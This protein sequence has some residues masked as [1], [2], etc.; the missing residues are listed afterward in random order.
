MGAVLENI[1]GLYRAK[2]VSKSVSDA[3]VSI[4]E[5]QLRPGWTLLSKNKFSKQDRPKRYIIPPARSSIL[6]AQSLGISISV[7]THPV[8]IDGGILE[9]KGQTDG[10]GGKTLFFAAKRQFFWGSIQQLWGVETGFRVFLIIIE[11]KSRLAA[12]SKLTTSLAR[13]EFDIRISGHLVA[14]Q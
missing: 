9:W 10:N 1:L 8:G 6:R 5:K 3:R 4:G 11:T 12:S 7:R 14:L 13:L 2:Y